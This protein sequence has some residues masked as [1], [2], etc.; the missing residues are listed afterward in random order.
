MVKTF[1]MFQY[2]NKHTVL[3]FNPKTTVCLFQT[4]NVEIQVEPY[5]LSKE[6]AGRQCG[7][8]I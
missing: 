1:T 6:K 2:N 3:G 4:E 5:R 8:M 7:I